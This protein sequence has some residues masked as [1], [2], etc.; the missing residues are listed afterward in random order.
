M[1]SLNW[2]LI[3][4]L[5]FCMVVWAGVIVGTIALTAEVF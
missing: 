2:G 1:R 4:A 3:V 5:L